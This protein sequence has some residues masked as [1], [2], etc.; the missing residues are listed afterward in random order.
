[1]AETQS[2]LR[3]FGNLADNPEPTPGFGWTTYAERMNGRFAMVGIVLLLLVEFF[4]QQDF[5]TWLGLR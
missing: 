4:S 3:P 2:A 5:F 1:M